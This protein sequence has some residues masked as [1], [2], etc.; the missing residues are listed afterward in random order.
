M[1]G[2]SRFWG[3]VLECMMVLDFWDCF[4]MQDGSRL[5]GCFGLQVD[6]DFCGLFW[7]TRWIKIL[8]VV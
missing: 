4:V 7:Y 1:Q 3:V 6:Q 5:L 2:G 8:G